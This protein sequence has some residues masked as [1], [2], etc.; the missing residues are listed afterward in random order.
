[1]A[2]EHKYGT[3]VYTKEEVKNWI[4]AVEAVLGVKTGKIDNGKRQ[5]IY[6]LPD[7]YSSVFVGLVPSYLGGAGLGTM[8]KFRG[9][10][11]IVTSI[12]AAKGLQEAFKKAYENF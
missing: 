8:V 12:E 11:A 4:D 10:P 7:G 1:M 5:A 6:L 9:Y 3:S 2:I